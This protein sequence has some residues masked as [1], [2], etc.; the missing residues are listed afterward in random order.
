MGSTYER[1]EK[2]EVF[3]GLEAGLCGPISQEKLDRL[4]SLV[5]LGGKS[6]P[7]I[8]TQGAKWPSIGAKLL[9]AWAQQRTFCE[10]LCLYIELLGMLSHHPHLTLCHREPWKTVT[11]FNVLGM[12]G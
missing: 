7:M 8:D 2:E 12:A 4:R 11:V 6:D 5:S 9:C 3:A 10:A 1:A